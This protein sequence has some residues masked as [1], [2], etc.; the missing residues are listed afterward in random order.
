MIGGGGPFSSL[1]S[2]SPFFFSSSLSFVYA[3]PPLLLVSHELVVI[4]TKIDCG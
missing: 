2:L 4:N 1:P 3:Y